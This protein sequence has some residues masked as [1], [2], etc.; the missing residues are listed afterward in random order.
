[1]ALSKEAA[2]GR[3]NV[4][5][6]EIFIF[7]RLHRSSHHT[8]PFIRSGAVV[9]SS[10]SLFSS[11]LSSQP[12]SG[13]MVRVCDCF[14]SPSHYISLRCGVSGRRVNSNVLIVVGSSLTHSFSLSLLTASSSS[15]L[16]T[17]FGEMN[18]SPIV[19]TPSLPPAFPHLAFNYS[20]SAPSGGGTHPL[21]HPPL[22]HFS[23][24]SFP[25]LYLD[26]KPEV[27]G[28]PLPSFLHQ[29]QQSSSRGSSDEEKQTN[30]STPELV[31]P[32]PPTVLPRGGVG[33]AIF[34]SATAPSETRQAK[35][36]IPS[37]VLTEEH[38]WKSFDAA[39]NEMIVTK[40]GR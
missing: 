12:L 24:Y 2:N 11:L 37:A 16:F 3:G 7:Y 10:L 14:F 23:P 4:N 6:S 18:S 15:V 27:F 22:Y 13:V 21:S 38:L 5:I 36:L 9:L 20:P 35:D 17:F 29:Q 34:P 19:S 25:P 30:G 28:A 1:M 33:P 40:P 39:G 31:P 32:A 8:T 26:S